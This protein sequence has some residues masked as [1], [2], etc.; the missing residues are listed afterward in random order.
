MVLTTASAVGASPDRDGGV[1]P[2]KSAARVLDVLEELGRSGP[3]SLRDLADRLG[4]PKSSLHALL[5]TMERRGWLEAG[6]G[7][8]TYRVGLRALLAGSSYVDADASVRR[9]A[10]AMDELA[11]RTGEAVHLGRLDAPDVVYLAKRE[12]RHPLRL[13]SSVGRR[14]PAHSTALGKAVLAELAVLDP[15]VVGRLVPPPLLRST[16]A[17][18]TDPAEL[19]REVARTRERGYAVDDEESA[20][21]LRCYAVALPSGGTVTDA[22]SVSAP[23]ARLGGGRDEE[24]VQLLLSA[25]DHLS[26]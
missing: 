26:G 14:L 23:V 3:S 10:A 25:R 18:I 17:T 5:H 22:L 16:P 1:L 4:I 12:S 21:G 6:D 9:T 24:V 7:G 15:A 20:V 11:A 19:E 13:F 2:V 8:S